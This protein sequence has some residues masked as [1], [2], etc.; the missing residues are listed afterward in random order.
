MRSSSTCSHGPAHLPLPLHPLFTP[1]DAL[2]VIVLAAAQ[3]PVPETFA[4]V[5][6]HTH[7]GNTVVVVDGASAASEVRDVCEIIAI[8]AG[9]GA[10]IVLATMRPG[11]PLSVTP[12][13]HDAWFDMRD[14]ADDYAFEVIDWFV[15]ADGF[16]Q[17]MCELT[18]SRCLWR[19]VTPAR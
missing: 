5:L 6:D 1:H 8:A 15:V 13:D 12:A 14:I 11:S 9:P 17:S 19:G 4:L 2:E 7:Q 16:A 10:A 3:P 18:D